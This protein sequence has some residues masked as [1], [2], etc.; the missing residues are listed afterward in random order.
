MGTEP[1]RP[2]GTCVGCTKVSECSSQF[3]SAPSRHYRWAEPLPVDVD[4]KLRFRSTDWNQN[5]VNSIWLECIQFASASNYSVTNIGM[6]ELKRLAIFT[7]KQ[8]TDTTYWD[9]AVEGYTPGRYA[10][11]CQSVWE[12]FIRSCQETPL[13]GFF[14][15]AAMD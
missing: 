9:Y 3:D 12:K 6:A 15:N 13:L 14:S 2:C 11:I 4:H 7:V 8:R 1:V 5:L 10:E